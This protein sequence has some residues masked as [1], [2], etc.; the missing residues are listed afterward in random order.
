MPRAPALSTDAII[1]ASMLHFWKH[2]YHAT[3]ID[4]L[5]SVVGVNRHAIYKAV[6]GKRELYL[7]GFE[8]YQ[9][10]V[11]T[12]AFQVVE[13]GDANLD[14]VATFLETQIALAEAAGL[15]GLGCLVSNATTETAPHDNDIA[16]EVA[17]HHARLKAGFSNVLQN[18]ALHLGQ[19]TIATIADFLLINAQGL[20][21]MSRV[22]ATAAPLR[23]HAKTMMSIVHERV[24]Q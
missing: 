2:G 5:V 21:A 4:D 11:V 16:A 1:E 12:P 23:A 6:G 10:M 15:P 22:V 20:W 7:R 19:D 3:T 18:V 24:K 13:E 17:R 9:E 8:V 14:A